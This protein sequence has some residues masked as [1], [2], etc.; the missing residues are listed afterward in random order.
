M[1]IV[2]FLILYYRLPGLLASLA[3]II[4][5]F[6]VLSLFKLIPVT[7]T[8]AG[9]GGVILSIGMAVD[10]NILIFER[11]KEEL[12]KGNSL[13]PSIEEGFERAWPSIRDGNIT[14][15]IVAMI[16]FSF[17]T[18]FIKGFAFT[19][20]VGILMSMFSAIFITRTFLRYFIG[21]KLEKIK[22]LWD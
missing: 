19:L 8:L 2:L 17:G 3:L 14:T 21:T 10:A 12:K 18:S 7:L 15:L 1:L 22:W 11:T 13:G 16:L 9:I 4:Y 20:S 6:L 5:G